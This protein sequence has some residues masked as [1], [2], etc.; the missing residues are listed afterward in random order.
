MGKIEESKDM[1]E[2]AIWKNHKVIRHVYLTKEQAHT[3][4]GIK[5]IGLYFGFDE[6]TNPEKY[7][8]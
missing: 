6:K 8:N 7:R 3:L 4:N 5:D 2:Y 1:K